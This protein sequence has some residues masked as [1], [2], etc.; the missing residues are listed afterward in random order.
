MI[1]LIAKSTPKQS[2]QLK[3]AG[4]HIIKN[5]IINVSKEFIGYSEINGE[6]YNL[7]RYKFKINYNGNKS[8]YRQFANQFDIDQIAFFHESGLPTIVYDIIPYSETP[9]HH[10]TICK[11]YKNN[12]LISEISV[13]IL[14]DSKKLKKI[15]KKSEN[16]NITDQLEA[17][18]N[19]YKLGV[20]TKE[21]FE[22]AKKRILN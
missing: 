3:K 1:S 15:K 8:E 22:K 16:N 14:K 20:L 17:L 7:I 21:E 11:V 4:S 18:N 12:S 13:P 9:I 5:S 19:L 2:G 10:S 6:R